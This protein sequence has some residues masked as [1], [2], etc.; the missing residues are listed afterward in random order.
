MSFSD[1]QTVTVN[2]VAKVMPKILSEGG[3][4]TYRTA[5]ET[6]QMKISHQS[7]KS[8]TRRM[9]RIDQTVIAENPLT[10]INSSQKL[11]V[12]LVVDEPIFGFTDA[13]IDYVV[14][15]LVAWLTPANIAKVL[16]S[17]S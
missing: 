14:D 2:A 4:S 7:S 3:S 17:E 8:R 6:F 10:A 11:G 12:Y 1:P 15:G 16:G 5:D 13:D 9:V